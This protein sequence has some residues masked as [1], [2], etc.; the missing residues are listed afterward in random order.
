MKTASRKVNHEAEKWGRNFSLINFSFLSNF[1]LQL[2]KLVHNI[3]KFQY[4][5]KDKS[6]YS[7]ILIIEE[8]IY[9]HHRLVSSNKLV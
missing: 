1:I 8:I 5:Y 4:A 3:L 6:C 7:L 9:S 2:D